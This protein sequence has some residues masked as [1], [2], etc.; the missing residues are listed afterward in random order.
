MMWHMGLGLPWCWKLGPSNASERHHVKEMLEFGHFLSN[1]LFVGDAGFVGYEFWKAITDRGHHLL[2]RVGA[3]VNLLTELGTLQRDGKNIVYCWPQATMNANEVPLRLRLVKC[4]IGKNDMV[5]LL[6]SVL[7]KRELSNQE[8]ARLYERRWGVELQFRALKQTFDRRKVRCRNAER[9]LV[10]IEWSIFGMAAVELMALK[11]QMENRDARPE[12]L[13][14]SQALTVIRHSLNNLTN[15]PAFLDDLHS[16]LRR[17]LIDS[18]ERKKLKSGRYKPKR[19]NKPSCG[20]PIVECATSEQK[21][22]H[23]EI[24]LQNAA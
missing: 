15:C 6:T 14:F 23:Y 3:N 24:E 17:A 8:M 22:R 9:V 10:E 2:V 16:G 21:R 1:T 20:E 19:K 5:W 13:S 4:K 11:E 7:D 12:K 18:Y